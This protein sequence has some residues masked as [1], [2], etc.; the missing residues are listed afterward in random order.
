MSKYILARAS[1]K[2]SKTKTARLFEEN[3]EEA[4]VSREQQA[5]QRKMKLLERLAK[6]KQDREGNGEEGKEK[7]RSKTPKSSRSPSPAR[8]PSL[9]R[10]PSLG[11]QPT[12]PP[13][14][15]VTANSTYENQT[16]YNPKESQAESVRTV[17]RD[18]E[19]VAA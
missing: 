5:L 13:T 6:F 7:E 3:E 17:N 10:T 2:K 9:P 19:M 8:S 4:E 16:F 15:A 1:I 11:R 18:L 14:R 12:N